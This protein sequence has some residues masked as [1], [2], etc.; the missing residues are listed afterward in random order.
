MAVA[1]LPLSDGTTNTV[2]PVECFF[3]ASEFR[4]RAFDTET[5]RCL[6]AAGLLQW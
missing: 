1:I 6:E 4:L 2:D 3:W 5:L